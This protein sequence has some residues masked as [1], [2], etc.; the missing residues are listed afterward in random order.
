M[1]GS[2]PSFFDNPL[3]GNS[4][5]GTL[6]PMRRI[7]ISLAF[8]LLAW[9]TGA[10][11]RVIDLS[12]QAIGR[13]PA[14]FRALNGGTGKPGVWK[15]AA[16]KVAPLI[17]VFTP[18]AGGDTTQNVIAQTD[19]QLEANR[20]PMLLFEE[21]ELSEFTIKLRLKIVAGLLKEEAGI[22]FR[23]QDEKNYYVIRANPGSKTFSYSKIYNGKPAGAP[24]SVPA[25]VEKGKWHTIAV[26]CKASTINVFFDDKQIIPTMTDY[27]FKSGGVGLWTLG[28]TVAYFT[29][30][31]LDYK[32]HIVVAQQLVND[33][34]KKYSRLR[35]IQIYTLLPNKPGV[36][37][38][39]S[40]DPSEVGQ[41]GGKTEEQVIREGVNA[42]GS[43][44]RKKV[45]V[46]APLRD[47]NGDPVA[48]VRFKMN[49]FPGETRRTSVAKTL[50]ML[51]DMQRRVQSVGDLVD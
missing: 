43:E 13:A 30:I 35:G 2:A 44:G 31:K 42:Y 40:S 11:E 26:Q 17:P 19:T 34:M 6:P 27:T 33:T 32:H 8:T 4:G 1:D 28:D 14:N 9:N 16:E 48:A 39:A 22:A 37:L 3:A 15:I 49:R 21:E 10:A 41:V 29:D 25:P 50:P 45:T 7:L 46:L 36:H 12:T 20:T 23:I 18:G 38:V 47:R 51:R 5:S 24:I